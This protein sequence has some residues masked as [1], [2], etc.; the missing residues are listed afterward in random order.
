MDLT[1]VEKT[2]KFNFSRE[3]VSLT[4]YSLLKYSDVK[5]TERL[6]GVVL[7]GKFKILCSIF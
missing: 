6:L 2:L 3:L 1:L 5:N 4:S 7:Y